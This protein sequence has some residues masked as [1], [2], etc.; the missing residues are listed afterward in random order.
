MGKTIVVSAATV[1]LTI[2]ALIGVTW[3]A[4][5]FQVDRDGTVRLVVSDTGN[6]GIGTTAP[7]YKLTLVDSNS[8]TQGAAATYSEMT[9]NTTSGTGGIFSAFRPFL[10][11][12][13]TTASLSNQVIRAVY[14]RSGTGISSAFD[15]PFTAVTFINEG[16]GGLAIGLQ[17]EGPIMAA[18]KTLDTWIGVNINAPTGAGSVTGKY[19]LLTAPGAGNVGL[20]TTGPDSILELGGADAAMS[21]N[22]NSATPSSPVS[23][24]EAR[25]YMKADKLVI[26]YND[27]GTV[28]YKYLDLTGTGV[29]WTHT[30]TA[31]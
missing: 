29:T 20:G 8:G 27:G 7:G 15:A 22:E 24:T 3:A 4:N 30:T 25:I 21:L 10:R 28:R 2:A 12:S 1:T 16:I 9:R 17:V 14:T 19:A 31:P 5:I 18:S 6:V 23:G 26:Q 13:G 11:D